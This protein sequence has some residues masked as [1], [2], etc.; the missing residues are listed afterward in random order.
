MEKSPTTSI[1]YKT[2]KECNWSKATV[3]R[4]AQM[5]AEKL[6]FKV[7]GDLPGVVKSL[8]GEIIYLPPSAFDRTEDGS[9]EIEEDGSFQIFLSSFTHPLRDRFTVAHEL[10]HY[11]LHAECKGPFK[12]ERYGTG[13]TEWEANWF[14]SAF[15]MPAER[16]AE[17]F[18][19]NTS[20]S[21]LADIFCV[22]PSAMEV[23][24]KR[25]GLRG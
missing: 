25:L 6:G 1:I 2:P 9:I 20:I 19:K 15:L 14:A 3:E 23:R 17:E 11:F 21:D 8:N 16:V 5:L 4:Y 7:A 12:A 13:R 24:L 10:G 18:E 22:S